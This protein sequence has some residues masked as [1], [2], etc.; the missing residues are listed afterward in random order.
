MERF[1]FWIFL[2]LGVAAALSLKYWGTSETDL[3]RWH[4]LHSKTGFATDD[5]NENRRALHVR[6]AG[7]PFT[8]VAALEPRTPKALPKAA[9]APTPAP[10]AK[11]VDPKKD[12]K[13]DDKKKKDEK[14]KAA[15]DKKAKEG[16]PFAAPAAEANSAND[17]T[18]PFAAG[19]KDFSSGPEDGNLEAARQT[20][21]FAAASTQS[22]S[23]KW[24]LAEWEADLLKEPQTTETQRFISLYKS[25][26]VSSTIFYDIVNMMLEDS[27][28]AMRALGVTCLS[29]T[30]SV[31]SLTLLEPLQTNSTSAI[32]SQAQQALA[33]YTTV[34]NL[35]ILY[36]ILKSD[37]SLTTEALSLLTTSA[38]NNLGTTT[39][40]TTAGGSTTG[41]S[42]LSYQSSVQQSYSAFLTVLQNLST[43]GNSQVQTAASQALSTL[44]GLLNNSSAAAKAFYSRH[45]SDWSS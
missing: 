2:G 36:S 16:S 24:T 15:A 27:R 1:R 10:A 25:G 38:Q 19:D 26:A 13:K 29:S 44:E 32:Q 41:A 40:S 42:T 9:P 7:S 34:Q 4:S 11:P 17:S 20:A 21:T 3:D 28:Q 39:T 22:S 35:P 6:H 37:S 12:T 31:A 14:K 5:D 45:R 18:S 43:Q 33:A 23:T 30:P 8:K